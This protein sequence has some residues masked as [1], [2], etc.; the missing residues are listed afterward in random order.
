MSWLSKT[1]K[2]IVNSIKKIGKAIVK[3]FK[4]V[5]GHI[6]KGMNKVFG[7]WAPLAMLAIN[8]FTGG[9]GGM[10]SSAWEGFGSMAAGAAGSANAVI[11]TIGKIGSAI[12]SGGNAVGGFVGSI[13][14]GLSKGFSSLSKG[15]FS[16]AFDSIGDGFSRAFSGEASS[17]AMS[18]ASFKAFQS[19]TGNAGM[20]LENTS[21]AQAGAEAFQSADAIN[22]NAAPSFEPGTLLSGTGP[23]AG[24]LIGTAEPGSFLGGS[25]IGDLA[26]VD[27]AATASTSLVPDVEMGAVDD[28]YSDQTGGDSLSNAA[29][30]ALKTAFETPTFGESAGYGQMFQGTD[31]SAQGFL[32]RSGG[33]ISAGGSLLDGVQ[34]LRQSIEESNRRF[35]R[36]F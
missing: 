2:K 18:N 25:P 6:G 3:P 21:A 17:Q 32:D 1:F 31:T 33:G 20:A 7:K 19:S 22:F 29:K 27:F 8:Y 30:S 35:A 9:I 36:G 4:K 24:S 14:E 5:L 26:D 16:N 10:L 12:F 23:E 28:L 15:N 34:G 13:S 11:A